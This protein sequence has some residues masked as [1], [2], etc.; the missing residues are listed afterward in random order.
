MTMDHEKFE[1]V[2]RAK[3]AEQVIISFQSDYNIPSKWNLTPP[4]TFIKPLS[5]KAPL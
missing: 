4:P 5:N 1:F 2:Q 3:L